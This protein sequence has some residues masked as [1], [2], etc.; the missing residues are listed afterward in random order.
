MIAYDPALARRY[1]EYA[2]YVVD[3]TLRF[4]QIADADAGEHRVEDHAYS[5]GVCDVRQEEYSLI[6]LLQG[7]DR[8]QRY[9]YQ[10]RQRR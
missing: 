8:V 10:K 4:Y 9:G 5:Y 1:A 7:L 3:Y 2:D 6:Y